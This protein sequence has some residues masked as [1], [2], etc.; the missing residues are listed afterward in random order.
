[1]VFKLEAIYFQVVQVHM[2]AHLQP[3]SRWMDGW[4]HIYIYTHWSR[5]SDT[6]TH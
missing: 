6:Y 4:I 1:M 5:Q 2:S 3:L